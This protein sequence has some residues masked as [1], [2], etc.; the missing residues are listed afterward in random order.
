MPTVALHAHYT[1]V[2]AAPAGAASA[3]VPCAGRLLLQGKWPQG[4]FCPKT[5]HFLAVG[6]N[7]VG[8]R[9][10]QPYSVGLRQS[11][12]AAGACETLCLLGPTGRAAALLSSSYSPGASLG[13]QPVKTIA[14]QAN[15]VQ[16]TVVSRHAVVDS[17]AARCSL[18]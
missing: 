4:T 6:R 7:H 3:A 1:V 2:T 17:A 8:N 18:A 13:Q 14:V 11:K 15:P 10:S 12:A 5:G 9:C 16:G